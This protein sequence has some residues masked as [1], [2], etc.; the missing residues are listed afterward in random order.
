MKYVVFVDTCPEKYGTTVFCL[1]VFDDPAKAQ[2]AMDSV[3]TERKPFMFEL[4]ENKTYTLPSRKTN[5]I[6]HATSQPPAA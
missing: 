2:A 5:G 4:E 6:W 3:K 1:G